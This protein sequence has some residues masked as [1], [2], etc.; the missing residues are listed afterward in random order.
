MFS[1]W[2]L[3]STTARTC[4]GGYHIIS[5]FCG[6]GNTNEVSMKI[7]DVKRLITGGGG[8]KNIET[9]K[10]IKME[11]YETFQTKIKSI[12]F[13]VILHFYIC[14]LPFYTRCAD[15]LYD[16]SYHINWCDAC[17]RNL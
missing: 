15:M 3:A 8:W 13:W 12:T 7:I 16:N 6:G 14:E 2:Y 10:P 11:M 1:F 9:N 17:Q 5:S 4:V